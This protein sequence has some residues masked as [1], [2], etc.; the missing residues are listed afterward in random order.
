MK[1]FRLIHTVQRICSTKVDETVLHKTIRNFNRNNLPLT[2]FCDRN[3]AS[4]IHRNIRD[5]INTKN[6]EIVSFDTIYNNPSQ[7]KCG[8]IVGNPPDTFLEQMLSCY[9]DRYRYYIIKDDQIV[10][11]E[12]LQ[13]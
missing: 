10:S 5:D 9:T 2:I 13:S 11:L 6:I 4:N 8:L 3:A 12:K 1:K 7:I